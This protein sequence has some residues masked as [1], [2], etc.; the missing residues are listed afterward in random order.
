MRP[1]SHDREQ[2]HLDKKGSNKS[3]ERIVSFE[4]EDKCDEG[5]AVGYSFASDFNQPPH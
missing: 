2:V 4:N 3:D 1:N 5:Q